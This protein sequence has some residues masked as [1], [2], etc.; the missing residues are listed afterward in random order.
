MGVQG[1]TVAEGHGGG[2]TSSLVGKEWEN[3]EIVDVFTRAYMQFALGR[4]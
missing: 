3:G 4:K 2:E 1:E